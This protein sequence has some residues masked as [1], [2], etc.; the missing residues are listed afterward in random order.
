[1]ARECEVLGRHLKSDVR[2]VTFHRPTKWLW[3]IRETWPA[4]FMGISRASPTWDMQR[5]RGAVS[6]FQHP[7]KHPAFL[8]GT[9]FNFLF[10]QFGSVPHPAEC[11]WTGFGD[12]EGSVKRSWTRNSRKIAGRLREYRPICNSYVPVGF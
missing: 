6:R 11:P 4:V 5:R 7:L 3:D 9:R 12:I 1:V 8:G 2:V 10:I